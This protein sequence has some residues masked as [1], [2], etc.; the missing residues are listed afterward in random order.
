MGWI[1]SYRPKQLCVL[2]I[3][4][5]HQRDCQLPQDSDLC[6]FHWSPPKAP[7]LIYQALNNYSPNQGL[8]HTRRR[9]KGDRRGRSTFRNAR[10]ALPGSCGARGCLPMVAMMLVLR[11]A[12]G[13]ESMSSR[14]RCSRKVSAIAADSCCL[15]KKAVPSSWVSWATLARR[16]NPA[17]PA[18]KEAAWAPASP[19]LQRTQRTLPP[20]PQLPVLPAS[21]ATGI[22]YLPSSHGSYQAGMITCSP[23]IPISQV[24]KQRPRKVKSIA[25]YHRASKVTELGFTSRSDSRPKSS[26]LTL[27]TPDFLDFLPFRR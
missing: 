4:S 15:W 11:A 25:P 6:L 9:R 26:S 10:E 2:I 17:G 22:Q 20:L 7:N 3:S 12:T 14:H 13:S 18:E 1:T 5:L 21:R 19:P 8:C 27:T 23:L 24:R 16:R